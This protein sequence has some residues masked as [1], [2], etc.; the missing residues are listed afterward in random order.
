MTHPTNR[1]QRR[2]LKNFEQ[3]K[4]QRFERKGRVEKKLQER[5]LQ[6]QETED[7]LKEWPNYS[8]QHL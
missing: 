8:N 1:Y 3:T 2:L 4:E 7:E 5:H 6:E